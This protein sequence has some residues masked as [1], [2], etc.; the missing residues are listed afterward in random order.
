[1]SAVLQV[2]F[3]PKTSALVS[4]RQPLLETNGGRQLWAC[5]EKENPASANNK[6]LSKD[7]ILR[8]R[9]HHW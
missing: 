2:P 7:G 5:D 1:M 9:T 3:G 8:A 6:L 4:L